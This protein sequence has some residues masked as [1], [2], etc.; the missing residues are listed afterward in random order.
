MANSAY[1]KTREL[2]GAPVSFGRFFLW[3]KKNEAEST[4]LAC[5]IQSVSIRK[6]PRCSSY[7]RISSKVVWRPPNFGTCQTI[8]LG[9]NSTPLS[10]SKISIRIHCCLEWDSDLTFNAVPFPHFSSFSI[11]LSRF[12]IF[13]SHPVPLNTSR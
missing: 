4:C 9:G 5:L 13:T 11:L 2:G 10:G 3:R 1:K 12:W 7:D 6:L 8:F